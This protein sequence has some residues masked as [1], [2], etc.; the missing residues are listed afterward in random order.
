MRHTRE[1]KRAEL[2]AEAQA[3]IDAYLKWEETAEAPT[4]VEIEEVILGLRKR[5][6]ER[7]AEVALADQAA[8]QPVE[9]PLCPTCGHAMRYKGRKASRIESRVGVLAHKRGYYHCPACASGLFPPG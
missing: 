9:A 8:T 5:L 4:L 6:G 1:Q 2:V 7:M 3:M